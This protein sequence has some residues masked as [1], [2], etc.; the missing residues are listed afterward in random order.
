MAVR[1]SSRPGRVKY[2]ALGLLMLPLGCGGEGL[3]GPA[4]PPASGAPPVVTVAAEGW[5][6][7]AEATAVAYQD[8]PRASGQHYP[9]YA[10]YREHAQAVP[11]PHWVHNLKH[12]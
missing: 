9:V 3:A 10:R 2:A 8:N 5:A 7:V 12:G 11:R 1:I 6:H 4:G